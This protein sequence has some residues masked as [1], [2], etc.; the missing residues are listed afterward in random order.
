MAGDIDIGVADALAFTGERFTPEC[1]REIWYEHMHRYAFATGLVAG[2]RVLDAACG[3]GYGSALL[4][5][6]AARVSGVDIDPEAI[7]H[8]RA[9][10]ADDGRIEFFEA[11][12]CALPFDDDSFDCI[13]SFETVEHLD[14]QSGL[15]G[16][17]RRVLKPEGFALISSPDREVY[18]GELGNENPWHVR[19]LDRAEFERLV[20]DHF[21]AYTVFEQRL[22]FH[23]V[24]WDGAD[25]ER[26]RQQQIGEAGLRNSH[27]PPARGVYLLAL[28][29]GAPE[30]LPDPGAGMWLF[31]DAAASVYAHYLHEIRKNMSAGGLLADLQ[32]QNADLKAELAALAPD[33]SGERRPWWR[34]LFGQN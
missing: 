32:R 8:A 11:D 22:M 7:A 28:C 20:A 31:S 24:I 4:G 10:Y 27:R 6:F 9:R 18:S 12:C 1:Q 21:P 2:R 14:N 23:S 34:R 30:H 15:F 5:R 13:V 17:L 33:A 25:D 19:E 29:A 26:C 16:E 3:E